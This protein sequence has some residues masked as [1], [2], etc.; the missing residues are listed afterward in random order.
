MIWERVLQQERRRY[1]LRRLL[2][3]LLLILQL[4][5]VAA[6]AAALAA[7]A[8]R[9]PGGAA[10][11]LVV[12]VDTGA[13]MNAPIGRGTRLDAALRHAFILV[14]DMR[15]ADRMLLIRADSFP[16]ILV[17]FTDDRNALAGA[18]RG[19]APTDEAADLGE[20]LAMAERLARSAGK[21]RIV[22]LTDG[23]FDE[24]PDLAVPVDLITTGEPLSNLAI[25]ALRPRG[26]EL[27][28]SVGNYSD[29]PAVDRL[30]V[31]LDGR[32]L[33][34][35]PMALQAGEERNLFFPWDARA[36]VL[37]ARLAIGDRFPVDD[38][39]RVV[40][41]S[42]PRARVQLV[43]PGN[44]FLESLLAVFPELEF[45]VGPRYEDLPGDVVI[46]DRVAPQEP[47]MGAVL[48]ID[49]PPPGFA[50]EG[51]APGTRLITAWEEEHPIL[52][53]VDL[54]GVTVSEA[55]ELNLGERPIAASDGLGLIWALED[56]GSRS[57]VLAFDLAASDLP[58]RAAF[59][60]LFANALAW[61]VPQ[62][63]HHSLTGSPVVLPMGGES[64]RVEGP[65]GIVRTAY[66]AF[67]RLTFRD[68]SRAGLYTVTEPELRRFAVNLESREESD[69]RPRV[70]GR[71]SPAQEPGETALRP[72][73][74][75]PALLALALLILELIAQVRRW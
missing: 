33:L 22:L 56:G 27:M 61:L 20:A 73:W 75:A 25:T 28:V 42:R 40:V 44:H 49:L 5:A 59:P 72:L 32:P 6:L 64:A 53:Q 63:P 8:A 51:R 37:E 11:S 60:V 71:G 69:L 2:Q 18:L 17:P 50:S 66:P 68:T 54:S 26:S 10:R 38:T 3:N 16:D 43:T 35:E 12:I 14:R 13:S 15:G 19:I 34:A 58:F 57:A 48:Y 52:R 45:T 70:T 24:L 4:L 9:L 46:F 65:D 36:G 23:A 30:E 47:V 31:T 41:S 29:A 39:A 1:R 62:P 67:G 74:W 55:L 7:P 21:G